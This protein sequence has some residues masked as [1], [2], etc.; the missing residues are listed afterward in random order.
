MWEWFTTKPWVDGGEARFIGSVLTPWP[1]WMIA[2]H[3]S[4]GRAPS[5][6]VQEFLDTLS[7]YVCDF[8][9]EEKRATADVEFIKEKFNYPEEDIKAWLNTVRYPTNCRNISV[10]VIKETLDILEKA[11]FVEPSGEFDIHRFV[12]TEISILVD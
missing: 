9:S 10:K 5:H 3:P 8:D 7:K 2:D 11:G 1:S 4:A 6:A 12:N